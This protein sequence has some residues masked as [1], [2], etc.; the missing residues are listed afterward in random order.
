MRLISIAL[1]T[2]TALTAAP[3]F[4]QNQTVTISGWGGSEVAIVNG[5]LTEVVAEELAAAGIT[6]NYEPVDGDFSQF[7]IN[8]LSAGT[9]P[10]LFYTDIFWARTVF[11]A[12]QAAP[13][14]ADTDDFAPNLLEAF[15]YEGQVLSLPKDFNTLALHYNADIFDEAGVDYPTSEDT[16]ETLEE[17]LVAIHDATGV[18][19]TCVVP[20]YARFAPFALATG[21]EPFNAEGRTV[22]DENFRRAFE[23]Y[24]GLATKG[25]GAAVPAADV[26]QGWTGG[27]MVA[28]EAAVSVEGAWIIGAIRDSAPNMEWG[29]VRLPI[30]PQTGERGNLIFTVGWTVN[31]SSDVADAAQTVAA[32]LT[33]EAA[34]QWVLEQGL[35]LPS[36]GSLADN[37]FLQGSSPESVTNRVV[38]EGLEDES[39]HPYFFGDLGGTWMEPL[40]TALN[41]VMLGESD[42]D[43]ALATAQA[44]FD[45]FPAQ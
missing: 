26:G 30:D 4:A 43:T 32:L 40:N 17:K 41:A 25:Q 14:T 6:V 3:A 2:G 27:C 31:A 29:T 28:E 21:W 22:L 34:Q 24:T 18:Y 23:W 42:I 5:L 44:R 13:S 7:I 37:A 38:F 10:D 35:A 45:E 12:G 11:S 1:L 16:W 19:G 9:A 8:G 39:V 15:T 36:R 33:S 20:D